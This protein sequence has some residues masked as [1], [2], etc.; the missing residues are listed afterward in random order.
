MT[1]N[2]MQGNRAFIGISKVGL[3]HIFFSCCFVRVTNQFIAGFSW[4]I[5]SLARF[6]C[7]DFPLSVF[8]AY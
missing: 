5:I 8:C 3:T 6:F 4:E 1:A 2:G 7:I